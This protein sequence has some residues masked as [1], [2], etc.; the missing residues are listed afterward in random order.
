M[1]CWTTIAI[2]L[3]AQ[4]LFGHLCSSCLFCVSS[5]VRAKN[6]PLPLNYWLDAVPTSM[7]DSGLTTRKVMRLYASQR[8]DPELRDSGDSSEQDILAFLR[9][10]GFPPMDPQP[11][12]EQQQN[13]E[14]PEPE[15]N[16]QLK[17]FMIDAIM[18][19]K[20][21]LSPLMPKNCRFLPTCSQYGLDAINRYGSIRGG[22][23]TVWRI[24]RCNP[25]GGSGYDAPVWPPPSYFAGSNTFGGKRGRGT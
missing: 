1:T 9:S 24:F 7:P 15:R 19:Y 22:L 20:T 16:P 6:P 4:A 12:E 17:Q 8:D 5:K 3:L 25:I 10:K 14:P 18:W 13:G 21:S 11:Q 2:V 23:L